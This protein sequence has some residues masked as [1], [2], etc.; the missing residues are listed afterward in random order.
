MLVMVMITP[1]DITTIGSSISS[2]WD[3]IWATNIPDHK[4]DGSYGHGQLMSLGHLTSPDIC[5]EVTSRCPAIVIPDLSFRELAVSGAMSSQ[6]GASGGRGR[7]K[8]A[9]SPLRL[10]HCVQ[11]PGLSGPCAS[12]FCEV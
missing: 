2:S 8:G 11:A 6:P 9:Y 10:T 1:M 4:M 5:Y 3:P 7:G 12:G